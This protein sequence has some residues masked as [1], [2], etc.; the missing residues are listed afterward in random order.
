MSSSSSTI[1]GRENSMAL[2]SETSW[3]VRD[4]EESSTS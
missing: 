3:I 4:A 2:L 1:E